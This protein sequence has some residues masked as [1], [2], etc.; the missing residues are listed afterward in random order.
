MQDQ[1][2]AESQVIDALKFALVKGWSLN[3]IKE[4]EVQPMRLKT[5]CMRR[6]GKGK[7]RSS[8]KQRKE[9]E[10]SQEE[11]DDAVFYEPNV[12]DLSK[13]GMRVELLVSHIPIYMFQFRVTIL[14]A[15]LCRLWQKEWQKMLTTDGPFSSR[16]NKV[17]YVLT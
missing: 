7:K 14:V 3:R 5:V 13:V 15:I 10:M 11:L 8:Q 4:P 1:A 12:P 9:T 6:P 16:M 17:P 2:A